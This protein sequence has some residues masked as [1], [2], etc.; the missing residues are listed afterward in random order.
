MTTPVDRLR[1]MGKVLQGHTPRQLNKCQEK[2]N[3]SS[4]GMNPLT[5]Y[6]RGQPQNPTSYIYI[7]ISTHI[8]KINN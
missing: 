6:S 5:D 4:Q 2:K 3:K 1:W 7:I 8:C